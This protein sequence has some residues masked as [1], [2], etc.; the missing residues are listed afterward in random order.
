MLN[1]QGRA[2]KNCDGVTRRDALKIG[3]LAFGGLNTHCHCR[4]CCSAESRAGGSSH[5]AIIMIY[6]CGAPGHQDLYDLKM[7]APAEIR[8]EFKPI[9]NDRSRHGTCV[10]ICPAWQRWPTRLFPIRSMYGSP[11]GSH[12]SFICYTGKSFQNQPTGGWPAIGSVISQ[13]QGTNQ[14]FGATLPRD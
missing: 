3:T 12:D 8:G 6:M 4:S 10:S 1:L 9:G 2:Y 7:E 13:L 5:K 14:S 11:N